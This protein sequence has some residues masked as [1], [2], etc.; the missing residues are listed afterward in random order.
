MHKTSMDGKGKYYASTFLCVNN[1]MYFCMYVCLKTMHIRVCVCALENERVNVVFVGC[2]KVRKVQFSCSIRTTKDI[3]SA[4][5]GK[6]AGKQRD[7]E[8]NK[9]GG[10]FE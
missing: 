2:S 4:G 8:S 1:V 7:R 3:P 5:A 10:G 6:I 9:N